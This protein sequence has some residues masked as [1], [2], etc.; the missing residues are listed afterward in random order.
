MR[1]LF[2]SF[3]L[4]FMAFSSLSGQKI[5]LGTNSPVYAF[6]V[7]LKSRFTQSVLVQGNLGIGTLNPLYG[8]DLATSA[9]IVKNLDIGINTTVGGMLGIGTLN[10]NYPLQCFWGC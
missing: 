7:D 5:G 1:T 2:I 8:L 4:L 3:I 10:P 9:R 6:D